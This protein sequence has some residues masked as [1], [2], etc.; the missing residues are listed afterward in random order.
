MTMVLRLTVDD[1]GIE[2][3]TTLPHQAAIDLDYIVGA[4]TENRSNGPSLTAIAMAFASLP[5][6]RETPSDEGA[7]LCDLLTWLLRMPR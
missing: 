7:R 1:D 6:G 4:L 3:I 2:H 5:L